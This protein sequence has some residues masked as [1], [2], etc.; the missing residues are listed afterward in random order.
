ML[1]REIEQLLAAGG[2]RTLAEGAGD[3]RH[4][5]IAW[6]AVRVAAQQQHVVRRHR[7]E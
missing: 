6:A 3:V 4:D 7:S 2:Q 1:R 5:L